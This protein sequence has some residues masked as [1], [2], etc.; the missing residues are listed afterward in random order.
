MH[1]WVTQYCQTPNYPLFVYQTYANKGA[2]TNET[3][4]QKTEQK[5]STIPTL[6]K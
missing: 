3:V 1:G 4:K 6:F 2:Q 5:I